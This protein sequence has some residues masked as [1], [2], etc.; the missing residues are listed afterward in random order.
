MPIRLKRKKSHVPSA[1]I[2]RRLPTIL[3]L[4]SVQYPKRNER[5]RPEA[6][7]LL[8]DPT[9]LFVHGDIAITTS[10]EFRP[11]GQPTLG[12]EVFVQKGD[13]VDI[14]GCVTQ[15]FPG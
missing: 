7:G 13:E 5:T 12:R 14:G 15:K 11:E 4:P 2:A 6:P 3:W 8:P 9:E 1:R 10:E